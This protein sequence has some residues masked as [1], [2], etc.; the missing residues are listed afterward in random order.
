MSA[1]RIRITALM[2]GQMVISGAS[3]TV[4]TQQIRGLRDFLEM[5][6][7]TVNASGAKAASLAADAV[8]SRRVSIRTITALIAMSMGGV[9]SLNAYLF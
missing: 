1:S 9:L 6:R 4:R 5:D 3:A 7:V 2:D 8:S